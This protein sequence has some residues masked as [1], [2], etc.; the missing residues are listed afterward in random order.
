MINYSVFKGARLLCNSNLK[1]E[2]RKGLNETF[3]SRL[4]IYNSYKVNKR[5]LIYYKK[6]I[7][8]KKHKFSTIRKNYSFTFTYNEIIKRSAAEHEL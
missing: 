3:F 1:R 8:N 2:I 7:F 6:Y 4:L 5:L